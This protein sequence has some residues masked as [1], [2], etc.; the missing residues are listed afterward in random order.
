MPPYCSSQPDIDLASVA[1][2]N[3]DDTESQPVVEQF[4]K[5][6]IAYARVPLAQGANE[7]F[8]SW[9]E[10]H[11]CGA[12]HISGHALASSVVQIPPGVLAAGSCLS[13]NEFW[14]DGSILPPRQQVIDATWRHSGSGLACLSFAVCGEKRERLPDS[15]LH[16]LDNGEVSATPCMWWTASSE[17]RR[18]CRNLRCTKPRTTSPGYG[19][20][21]GLASPALRGSMSGW[22]ECPRGRVRSGRSRVG[23]LRF[24]GFCLVR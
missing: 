9:C 4:A 14:T 7:F 24:W 17:A 20:L 6:L 1:A 11:R 10:D 2:D 19:D 18:R 15:R 22:V 12:G 13:I 8:P 23:C 21:I 5:P 16:F 3:I